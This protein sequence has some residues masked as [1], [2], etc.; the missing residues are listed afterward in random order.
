VASERGAD[1]AAKLRATASRLAG[2]QALRAIAAILVIAVHEPDYERSL[3]G[4]SLIQRLAVP[5]GIGVDLFFVVSGFIM[6]T[7][8]WSTGGS[9]EGA[10]AFFQRRIRR[11]YPLYWVMTLAYLGLHALHAHTALP[12]AANVRDVVASLLLVPHGVLPVLPV[13]WTL[14]NEIAFYV[15]F[16]F[17]LATA[18]RRL[19]FGIWF[20]TIVLATAARGAHPVLAVATSPLNVE[21]LLGAAVGAFVARGQIVAPRTLLAIGIAGVLVTIAATSA[22]PALPDGWERALTIGPPMAILLYGAVGLELR[23][24]LRVPRA[25]VALGDASYSLYLSHLL[26]LGLVTTAFS[27]VRRVETAHVAFVIVC[28]AAALGASLVLYRTVE[29]PLLA[30]VRTRRG[31][32]GIA[33]RPVAP[34]NIALD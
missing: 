13:G 14:E 10:G 34:A 4:T 30:A 8:T 23:A 11:I 17:A 25:L 20:A 2:V 32:R 21:F 12:G 24:R 22:L 3:F 29:R 6:I 5:G 27:A 7:T 15:V 16:A 1:D 9:V 26:V 28:Y 33:M 19:V 31:S 18:R